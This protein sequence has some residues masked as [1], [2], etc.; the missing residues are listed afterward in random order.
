MEFSCENR[1]IEVE[2]FIEKRLAQ[3]M[4]HHVFDADMEDEIEE[5]KS[6]DYPK[7]VWGF[8]HDVVLAHHEKYPFMYELHYEC[9]ECKEFG[10]LDDTDLCKDC[11][12]DEEEEE[13]ASN[14]SSSATATPIEPFKI[15][16]LMKERMDEAIKRATDIPSLL[17]G[18]TQA[19]DVNTVCHKCHKEAVGTEWHDWYGERDRVAYCPPCWNWH[20][21]N[22]GTDHL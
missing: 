20:K 22:G 13:E 3:Y 16:S 19:I 14:S 10:D 4:V 18:V 5:V 17:E 2:L 6:K 9:R 7:D 1:R 15:P 8:V 11:A 21:E 12:K